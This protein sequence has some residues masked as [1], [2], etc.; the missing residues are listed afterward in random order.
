MLSDSYRKIIAPLFS[1]DVDVPATVLVA[2]LVK[3]YGVDVFEWDGITIEMQVKDDVKV[4]MPR[5][6]FD[7][8]MV[9]ITAMSTTAVYVDVAAFDQFIS[10]I[11]GSSISTRKDIPS[12]EEVAWAVVELRMNDPEPVTVS[13]ENPFSRD[14]RKYVRVVLDN[15]GMNIPPK[16]LSFVEGTAPQSETTPDAALVAGEWQSKQAMADEIDTLVQGELSKLFKKLADI[17]VEVKE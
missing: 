15:E 9:L 17:G 16:A 7:K 1:G 14:V 11:N 12:V 8:V 3:M 4:D 6:V 10:A 5:R 13:R 2:A